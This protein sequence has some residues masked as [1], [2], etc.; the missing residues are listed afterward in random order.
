MIL[1][2]TRPFNESGAFLLTDN[3]LITTLPGSG[4]C[5]ILTMFDLSDLA[6]VNVRDGQGVKNAFKVLY[7]LDTRM[8]GAESKD[9]KLSW[10]DQIERA[11]K[12]YGK[13]VQMDAQIFAEMKTKDEEEVEKHEEINKEQ[14]KAQ[15]QRKESLVTNRFPNFLNVDWVD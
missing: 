5:S 10:L 15:V 12:N 14:E 7:S 2:R 3:L 13:G 9:L 6:V 1:K 8:F 11:K 4:K